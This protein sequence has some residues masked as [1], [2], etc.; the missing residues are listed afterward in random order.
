MKCKCKAKPEPTVRWYRGTQLISEGKKL[1]IKSTM[2]AE[3][4]FELTLEIQDP[5]ASDGGTYR[6]NVQNEYGESNANLNLNI[7]ADPEPEGEGL[8]L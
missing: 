1:K 4:T 2:I 5:G 6:C 8:R 3:D 7:E